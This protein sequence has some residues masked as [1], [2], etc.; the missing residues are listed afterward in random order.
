M[1]TT[2]SKATIKDTKLKIAKAFRSLRKKGVLA[3]TNFSCCTTCG[4][5]EMDRDATALAEDGEPII[6]YAFYHGQDNDNLNEGGGCHIGYDYCGTPAKDLET[7][8]RRTIE[9]GKLVFSALTA[10]GLKCDWNGN[11][12]VKVAVY[13]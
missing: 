6:G 2:P 13:Q 12:S 8:D 5:F 9:I 4:N 7:S 3:R 10:V 11:P 1:N